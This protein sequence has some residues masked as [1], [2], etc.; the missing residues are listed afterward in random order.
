MS[1]DIIKGD[2]IERK[3]KTDVNFVVSEHLKSDVKKRKDKTNVI[4][5]LTM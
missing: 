3:G 4:F 2:M 1:S 5:I